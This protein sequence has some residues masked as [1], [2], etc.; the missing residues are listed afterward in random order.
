M[1]NRIYLRPNPTPKSKRQAL[2]PKFKAAVR[3]GYKLTEDGSNLEHRAVWIEHH[4]AILSGWVV[5]HIDF[6]KQNN[7]IDNLVALP[8]HY[9]N[10]IHAEMRDGCFKYSKEY[11]MQKYYEL[12]EHYA[13]VVKE[14]EE[15]LK[16]I[17]SLQR[18]MMEYGIKYVKKPKR[19][20]KKKKN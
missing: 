18:K 4:G 13:T 10:R 6:D 9:H 11:L 8:E 15:T 17:E 2:P 20:K 3:N 5:H 7:D 16:K 1:S 19:L 12:K 14:Y